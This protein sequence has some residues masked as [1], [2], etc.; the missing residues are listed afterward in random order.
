MKDVD[1]LEFFEDIALLNIHRGKAQF[2]KLEIIADKDV[3]EELELD[4]SDIYN[5][6]D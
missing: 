1:K 5:V 4:Y 6:E 3:I 2:V